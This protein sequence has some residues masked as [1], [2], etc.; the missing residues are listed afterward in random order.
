MSEAYSNTIND[1]NKNWLKKADIEHTHSIAD[2]TDLQ[3]TL[4]KKLEATDITELNTKVDT[5]TTEISN[6]KNIANSNSKSISRIVNAFDEK[7]DKTDLNKK[8]DVGHTHSISDVSNLQ[9]T[10]N[11]KA[12]KSHTHSISDISNLQTA[13]DSKAT[14][15]HRHQIQDIVSLQ[16][17]LDGKASTRHIHDIS[18]ISNLQYTL[19]N[20]A[21]ASDLSS[22]E[23][24]VNNLSTDKISNKNG[25]GSLSFWTGTQSQYNSIYSKDSNTIYFITE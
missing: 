13:L 1:F 20:K 8:S 23:A 4:D 15:G 19:N 21:S 18:D 10:L 16:Y 9:T 25:Y 6:M 12:S 3:T 2:V 14:G 24:K 17:K 7:A 11:G 22:L 5:N